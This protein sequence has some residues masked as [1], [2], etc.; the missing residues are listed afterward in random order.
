MG[1]I[2]NGKGFTFFF[3]LERDSLERDIFIIFFS[4]FQIEIV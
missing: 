4:I 1:G 3:E 2:A